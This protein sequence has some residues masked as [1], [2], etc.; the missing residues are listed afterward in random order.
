[1]HDYANTS[2]PL[3]PLKFHPSSTYKFPKRKFVVSR[4]RSFKSNWCQKYQWLH[5]DASSDAAFCYLCMRAD[6]EGK[7]LV[8]TR[9]EPAF[10]SKGFTYWKEATTAFNKHQTSTCHKE[11]DEAINL[12]HNEL[13]GNVD[14]LLSQEIKEQKADNRKMLMKILDFLLVKDYH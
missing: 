11:A 2:N 12:L 1:M 7:L 8:S 3:L 13:L 10:I 6:K 5:Y 4:E 9:K 14:D